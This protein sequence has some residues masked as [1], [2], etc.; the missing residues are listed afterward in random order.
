MKSLNFLVNSAL[1]IEKLRVASEVRQSHLKLQGRT[2]PETNDLHER[3][4]SLEKYVDGR[5]AMLLKEHPAYFWFSKVKGVGKENIGKVVGLVRVE[6]EKD[7]DGNDLPYADTIS[8]LWSFAGFGVEDGK[9][10]KRKQGDKLTYNSQ[11]R[12]MTWRLTGSLLKAKG[13][14][15]DYYVAQ[16]ERYIQRFTNEGKLIVPATQLPKIN[17]KKQEDDRHISEGHI[18]NM[19]LRKTSKLFLSLLFVAWR[20]GLGLPYISPYAQEQLKHSHIYKLE[21]FVDKE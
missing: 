18:H 17:G 9:A 7:A 16:K 2:D 19:S 14:F 20:Q 11:L 13:K 10:P 15:Y 12:S 4:E 6:P 3:I 8:A 5:V 21:D 1:A